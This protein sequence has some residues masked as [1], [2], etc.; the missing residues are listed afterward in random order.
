MVAAYVQYAASSA[1]VPY[2]KAATVQLT[3][4]EQNTPYSDNNVLSTASSA[5]GHAD[6]MNFFWKNYH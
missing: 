1:S 4:R 5:T 3:M 2:S 6:W